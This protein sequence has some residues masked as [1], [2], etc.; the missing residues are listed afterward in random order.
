MKLLVGK[1]F[2]R[3]LVGID[4]RISLTELGV[5]IERVFAGLGIAVVGDSKRCNRFRVHIAVLGLAALEL[6]PV[7]LAPRL[8]LDVGVLRRILG[9]VRLCVGRLIRRLTVCRLGIGV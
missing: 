9:L 2:G 6:A 7:E 8:P 4:S 3:F 5:G 1:D